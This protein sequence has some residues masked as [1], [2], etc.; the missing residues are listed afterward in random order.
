MCFKKTILSLFCSLFSFI[1]LAQD[2]QDVKDLSFRQRLFFGGDLGLSFGTNTYIN[3]APVV[4]YRITNRLSAGLGPIYIFEKYKYYDIQTSSY[5]GKAIM[6]FAVIRNVSDY[7]NIGIGD[8]LLHAE[9]EIINL[10]KM[11]YV[12]TTGRI[13]ALDERLWIDNLLAG[14]GLNFPFNDRAGINI[15][16]LWDIT[17][18]EYSPYSN[19]VIRIGFY[20]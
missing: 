17:R 8:I 12:A 4:G 18:N 14:I 16:A 15:Y 19:P 11:E 7:L 3:L 1:I 20:F 2:V 5:G 9:N 6:S 13:Y 10:Q